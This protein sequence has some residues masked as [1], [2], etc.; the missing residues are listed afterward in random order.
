MSKRGQNVA[1]PGGDGTAPAAATLA[2]G[3]ASAGAAASAE[4]P[5]RIVLFGLPQAGKTALLAAL[6]QVQKEHP[7]LL[8]GELTDASG[9]LNR[10]RELYYEE[11]PR[12]TDDETL[13]YPVRFRP[14]GR[15]APALEAVL[16][17]SDGRAAEEM[18]EGGDPL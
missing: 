4:R 17:D 10:Q 6:A 2:A 18:L 1:A 7:S 12:P 3:A 14:G 11:I 15:K 5:L 13:A 9:G 8:S 16:V